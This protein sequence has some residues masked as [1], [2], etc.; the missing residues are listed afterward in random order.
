MSTKIDG[1]V[2]CTVELVRELAGLSIAWS[3]TAVPFGDLK[4][5]GDTIEAHL[6]WH[7]TAA[8]AEAM[9]RSLRQNTGG[10]NYGESSFEALKVG[11]EKRGNKSALRVIVLITDEGAH[12]DS[13]SPTDMVRAVIERDALVY[14]VTTDHSYYREIA[15]ATGGSFVPISATVDF[16]AIVEMFQRLASDI[17]GRSHKV[18]TSGGSP[19]RLLALESPR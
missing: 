2:A 15:E 16:S 19:Q 12:T 4:I 3:V 17:A 10:G 14:S 5:E 7:R 18:L 11:L 13:I 6:P 9:L 8:S 1:L